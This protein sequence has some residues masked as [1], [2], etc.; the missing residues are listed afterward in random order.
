[1]VEVFS[2]PA[3]AGDYRRFGG[4]EVYVADHKPLLVSL[5]A[6]ARHAYPGK[7]L[8]VGSPHR[9]GVVTAVH[10]NLHGASGDHV[11]DVD[12]GVGAECVAL[13]GE[14][15]AGVGNVPAVGS[16]AELL[17]APERFGGKFEELVGAEDVGG[18]FRSD[19][20]AQLSHVG[21]GDFG[22]PVVPVAVHEVFGGVGLSLVETRV[23]RGLH[24]GMNGGDVH[25]LLAVRGDGEFAHPCGDV[26][27]FHLLAQLAAAEG[28]LPDLAALDE[29]DGLS[30]RH[31]AG[32]VHALRVAGELHL[33]ASVEIAQVEVP[34]AFVVGYALVAYAVEHLG[35]VGGELGI[36]QAPEREHH[37]GGHDTIGDG[38]VL[39][40]YVAAFIFFFHASTDCRQ[41]EGGGD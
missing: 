39:R 25:Y 26:A 27:D 10:G 6:V 9:I 28:S 22:H 8:A 12:F 30:V 37:L 33:A 23:G 7:V 2:E 38:Y 14:L 40:P 3:D 24:R 35:A 32:A 34:A 18:L 1:M 41:H 5:V 29:E 13:S 16:P 19:V 36:A 31:P 20:V 4:G 21:A 11:I 15:A 17:D